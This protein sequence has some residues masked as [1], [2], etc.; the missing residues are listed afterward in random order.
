MIK[1]T[2]L[3]ENG[4]ELF[5]TYGIDEKVIVIQE[6]VPTCEGC[7]FFVQHYSM[8]SSLTAPCYLVNGFQKLNKGHCTARQL[9]RFISVNEK[10]CNLYQPK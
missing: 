7:K 10:T 4:M 1:T 5:S 2:V 8:P 9:K 3:T 6:R